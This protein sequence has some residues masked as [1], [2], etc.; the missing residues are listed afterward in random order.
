MPALLR[1]SVLGQ[2][3]PEMTALVNEL[4]NLDEPNEALVGRLFATPKD[5]YLWYPAVITM[6]RGGNLELDVTNEDHRVHAVNIQPNGSRQLLR[7]PAA[8]RGVIRIQ[9]DTPGMYWFGCPV[10]NHGTR[11]GTPT[12]EFIALDARSGRQLW[13]FRTGS[14]IHSSPISY[15]VNGIQYIAVPTGWG[16]WIKGFAPRT[17]GHERGK[18]LVRLRPSGRR[19]AGGSVDGGLHALIFRRCGLI[20]ADGVARIKL[21]PRKLHLVLDVLRRGFR[22]NVVRLRHVRARRIAAP[23]APSGGF[24][25]R[26]SFAGSAP[27]VDAGSAEREPR[28]L[29]WQPCRGGFRTVRRQVSVEAWRRIAEVGRTDLRYGGLAEEDAEPHPGECQHAQA[30][31]GQRMGHGRSSLLEAQQ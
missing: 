6:S 20:L 11:A 24:E 14:G 27:A 16:G 23:V 3:D 1:P 22:R 31:H 28:S 8:T 25:D 9:L 2:V 26:I 19:A 15:S 21:H 17:F 12:G 7:L 30:R 18:H 4:P 13:Q 10:E 29:L 5:E